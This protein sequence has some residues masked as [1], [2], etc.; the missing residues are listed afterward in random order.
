[1]KVL[2]SSYFLVPSIIIFCGITLLYWVN[3]D[4]TASNKDKVIYWIIYLSITIFIQFVIY[5][6]ARRNM[7]IVEGLES[8]KK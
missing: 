3:F 1:M 4:S 7:R 6:N 2:K 8:K 5:M